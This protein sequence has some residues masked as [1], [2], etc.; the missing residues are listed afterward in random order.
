MSTDKIAV[1]TNWENN[2]HLDKNSY[3]VKT[4]E[5]I[6]YPVI[7][8]PDYCHNFAH[9]VQIIKSKEEAKKYIDKSID[10]KICDNLNS[11]R[12][13]YPATCKSTLESALVCG[14]HLTLLPVVTS[15]AACCRIC[16]LCYT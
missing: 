14:V 3:E 9:G 5:C 12:L 6:N 13:L 1:K 10:T 4:L 2:A 15:T 16:T 7:F 11:N 8:K